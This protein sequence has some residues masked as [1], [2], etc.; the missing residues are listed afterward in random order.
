MKPSIFGFSTTGP[1][2][3]QY[4]FCSV[5]CQTHYPED[6]GHTQ[7]IL[8]RDHEGKEMHSGP[9][10]ITPYI[11]CAPLQ[12][13][14]KEIAHIFVLDA[15]ADGVPVHTELS[16]SRGGHGTELFP[17]SSCYVVLFR[18]TLAYQ[19]FLEFFVSIENY[20]PGNLLPHFP[21]ASTAYIIQQHLNKISI[22]E[23]ISKALKLI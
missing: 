10:K 23:Y 1:G 14:H 9:F 8:V 7:S 11:H 3:Q 19:L 16:L 2:E 18:R 22:Q 21:Q 20:S 5:D 12:P 4:N 15:D 6:I 17:E 13:S